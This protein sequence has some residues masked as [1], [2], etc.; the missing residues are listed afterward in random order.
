MHENYH[1][2]TSKTCDLEIICDL[3]LNR[4]IVL[5]KEEL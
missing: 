1:N 4:W 2:H 5:R 3:S